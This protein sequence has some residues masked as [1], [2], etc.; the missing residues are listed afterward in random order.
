VLR[1]FQAN[2]VSAER[3]ASEA[4]LRSHAGRHSKAREAMFYLAFATQLGASAA[5]QDDEENE[6]YIKGYN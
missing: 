5:Q 3:Y 1:N 4:L 2:V 6:N